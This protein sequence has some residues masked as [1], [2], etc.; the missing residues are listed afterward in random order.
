MLVARKGY[1]DRTP[2]PRSPLMQKHSSENRM[3]VFMTGATGYVGSRLADT[4]LAQGHQVAGLARS[5]ESEAALRRRGVDPV[6][7]N[8]KDVDILTAAARAADAVIH[9]AFH[10]ERDLSASIRVEGE[11]LAALLSAVRGAD[12][13]LIS[14]SG[15]AVLGDT[16]SSIFDEQTPIP[17]HTRRG[18]IDNEEIVLGARD[19]RGIV[20]RPPN[21]YGHGDG[22]QTFHKLR[23]VGQQ[24][25][26]IP[27]ASGSGDNLWSAVHVDDLVDLYTLALRSDGQQLYFAGAQSGLKTRDIAGAL[28][29]S[30]GWGGRTTELPIEEMRAAFPLPVFADYW[31]TNSQSSS[32][33]AKRL[34]GWKPSRLDALGDIERLRPPAG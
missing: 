34:L 25:K 21:V 30:M 13:P 4:L 14:T 3:K 15:T 26:A 31:A 6:R 20:L 11:A 18:R 8:L 12:K 22:T 16:G 33:K 10:I 1:S 7:G 5:V 32:E 29:H 27:F 28:S 9:T 17:P 24:F 19:A 23:H 2:S